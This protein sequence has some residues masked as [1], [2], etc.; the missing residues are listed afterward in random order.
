METSS[1]WSC[2]RCTFYN[3]SDITYCEMCALQKPDLV[4]TWVYA[5]GEKMVGAQTTYDQHKSEASKPK[6]P[7]E[8]ASK[9]KI[10][11]TGKSKQ[12]KSKSSKD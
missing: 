2:P 9:S 8:E 3:H 6:E 1:R 11:K 5:S 12:K 10:S 7:E 4:T